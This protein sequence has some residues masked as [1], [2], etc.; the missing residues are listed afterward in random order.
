MS[1]SYTKRQ[2]NSLEGQFSEAMHPEVRFNSPPPK[3]LCPK[4]QDA[5]ENAAVAGSQGCFWSFCYVRSEQC[6]RTKFPFPWCL[7]NPFS[8]GRQLSTTT[9]PHM[10]PYACSPKR[11]WRL[12]ILWDFISFLCRENGLKVTRCYEKLET[13]LK[14]ELKVENQTLTTF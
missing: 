2:R 7:E 3:H 10:P 5:W 12:A 1:R 6:H 9:P 11:K 13:Q 8:R 14:L 4:G